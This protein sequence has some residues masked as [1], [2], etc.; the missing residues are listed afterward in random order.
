[1]NKNIVKKYTAVL[2]FALLSATNAFAAN[3]NL[4]Q[5]VTDPKFKIAMSL[6]FAFFTLYKWIDFFANFDVSKA[7]VNIV[8]PAVLTFLTF[9]WDT[10]L[11][12]IG[13]I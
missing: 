12:W 2:G 5:I 9:K 11:G 6:G 13:L 10:V 3:A 1:M 8:L 7:L 4:T